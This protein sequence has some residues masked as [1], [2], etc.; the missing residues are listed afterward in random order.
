MHL[1][2][3]SCDC[4]DSAEQLEHGTQSCSGLRCHT[5][6][7]IAVLG[8]SRFG[9]AAV[10]LFQDGAVQRAASRQMRTGT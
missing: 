6:T 5:T 10:L 3:P 1:A 7:V 8:F 4:L 2:C 9:V